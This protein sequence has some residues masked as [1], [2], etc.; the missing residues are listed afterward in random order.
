MFAA[1]LTINALPPPPV[2]LPPTFELPLIPKH[3]NFSSKDNKE[4]HT[5]G[6]KFPKVFDTEG[7]KVDLTITKGL[8]PFMS[9]NEK[10]GKLVCN[11]TSADQFGT[12]FLTIRLMDA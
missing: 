8:L 12:F 4:G 11:P 6:F 1:T 2:N 5:K 3:L 7:T 9:Y 10:T